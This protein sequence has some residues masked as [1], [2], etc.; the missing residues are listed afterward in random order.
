MI[1]SKLFLSSTNID[2][3]FS[4][5]NNSAGLGGITPELNRKTFSKDLIGLIMSST[6]LLFDTI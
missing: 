1:V 5:N 2:F 4:L 3:I 6:L